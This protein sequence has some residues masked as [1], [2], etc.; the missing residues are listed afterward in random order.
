MKGQTRIR[1]IVT[2]VIGIIIHP[3]TSIRQIFQRETVSSA[4]V[5]LLFIGALDCFANF[6]SF[7]VEQIIKILIRI[8]AYLSLGLLCVMTISALCHW[9]A[10]KLMSGRGHYNKLFIC[11]AYIIAGVG[12]MAFV[13]YFAVENVIAFFNLP[14][15]WELLLGLGVSLGVSLWSLSLLTI[16]IHEVY[17]ISI[18]RSIITNITM[19]SFL[20]IIFVILHLILYYRLWIKRWLLGI[21]IKSYIKS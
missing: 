4:I 10:I 9:I 11:I 16:S 7:S 18:G 12:L 5:L 2:D 17:R 15:T 20:F 21:I 3:R 14:S 19:L 1:D 13:L 6:Q 8:G